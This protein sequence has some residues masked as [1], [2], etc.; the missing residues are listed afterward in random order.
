MAKNILDHLSLKTLHRL[1]V[2]FNIQDI[3]MDSLLGRKA[4]I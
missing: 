4:H 2:N 1:E 3:S